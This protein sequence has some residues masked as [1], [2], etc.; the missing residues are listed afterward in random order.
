MKKRLAVMLSLVLL[1]SLS[2]A[3]RAADSGTLTRAD[4]VEKVV[5]TL[6]PRTDTGGA[7]DFENNYCVH[8]AGSMHLPV[9]DKI[10]QG[11]P[12]LTE[13]HSDTPSL[14]FKDVDGETPG[15]I[16][17]NLAKAMGMIN[18]Y[19]GQVFRPA[20]TPTVNEAVALL[21]R[22]FGYGYMADDKG[23][24]PGGYMA[25]ARELGIFDEGSTVKGPQSISAA[26]FDKLLAL[27]AALPNSSMRKYIDFRR[28]KT[29]EELVKTYEKAVDDRQ[30][31][32]QY[33]LLSQP[34]REKNHSEFA[35]LNWVTGVSSPWVTGYESKEKAS[36]QY[37]VTF[38]YATSAWPSEDQVVSLTL[39]RQ[40]DFY[41]ITAIDPLFF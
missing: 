22:A 6:Y 13:L 26:D 16:Y 1:V 19:P 23:G 25:A 41:Q 21:V 18:G 3:G 7:F 10:G 11:F 8:A 24:F 28:P 31:V 36:L 20:Q 38:H 35:G 14:I 17:V 4:A 33:A 34:L 5:R 27:F 30:G 12:L 15:V 2:P 29:P 32:I 39:G 40:G 37:E 9:A